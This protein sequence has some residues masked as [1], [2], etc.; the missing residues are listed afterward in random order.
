M[1]GTIIEWIKNDYVSKDVLASE[2]A[3]LLNNNWKLMFEDE[4]LINLLGFKKRKQ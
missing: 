4:H 3:K 1:F 2:L